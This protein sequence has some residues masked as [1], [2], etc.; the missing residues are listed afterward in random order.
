MAAL[1]IVVTKVLKSEGWEPY[2]SR[3]GE[4][5]ASYGGK[6]VVKRETPIVLEG[7]FDKERLTVFEFPSLQAIQDLWDSDEYR[8]IRKL[9]DGLGELD[10]LAVQTV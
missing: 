7:R 5:F 3:V 8:E 10:V 2:Q 6:Y 4:C 1:M 9:R